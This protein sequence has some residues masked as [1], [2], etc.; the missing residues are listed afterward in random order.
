MAPSTSNKISRATQKSKK[1]SRPTAKSTVKSRYPC[2]YS[3]CH[4]TFSRQHDVIRHMNVHNAVTFKCLYCDWSSHTRDGRVIHE[5]KHTKE[6][7]LECGCK[8]GPDGKTPIP[9]CMERFAE[10]TKL[11]THKIRNH[12]HRTRRY[13]RIDQA[14]VEC[15]SDNSGVFIPQAVSTSTSTSAS[16]PKSS[17]RKTKAKSK[18][19]PKSTSLPKP[20]PKVETT[21]GT[22]ARLP[23]AAKKDR[24]TL[25]TSQVEAPGPSSAVASPTP[26]NMDDPEVTLQGVAEAILSLQTVTYFP[27]SPVAFI[28]APPNVEFTPAFSFAG[29]HCCLTTA[30]WSSDSEECSDSDAYW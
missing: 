29:N 18:A 25:P 21:L 13:R 22:R 9:V 17:K 26:S 2:T 10:P 8:T 7:P 16:T 1:S 30:Q 20:I 15:D 4:R 12:G 27:P 11:L 23:R 14:Q 24:N 6:K 5:R 28:T 3:N 19:D